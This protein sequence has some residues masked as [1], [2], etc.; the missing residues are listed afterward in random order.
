M[1]LSSRALL[2]KRAEPPKDSLGPPSCAWAALGSGPGSQEAGSPSGVSQ[3][4]RGSDVITK[5]Q[6]IFKEPDSGTCGDCG[7][8]VSVLVDDQ[9]ISI[10]LGGGCQ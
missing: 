7:A 1:C 9:P 2:G 6:G 5:R 10:F 4:Q 8:G 3:Q